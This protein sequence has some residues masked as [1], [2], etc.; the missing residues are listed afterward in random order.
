M[1]RHHL[2]PR[3]TGGE[4]TYAARAVIVLCFDCHTSLHFNFTNE[5]IAAMN[6]MSL[7][8]K[9]RKVR[10]MASFH[11]RRPVGSRVF[12]KPNGQMRV[13]DVALAG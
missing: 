4:Q 3:S 6:S 11:S 1:T 8:W 2:T 12:W 5:Q 10:A 9:D 7:L 13:P